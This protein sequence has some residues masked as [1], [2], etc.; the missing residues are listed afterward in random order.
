MPPSPVDRP[1][2]PAL[3]AGGRAARQGDT[4]WRA[5]LRRTPGGALALKAGVFVLGSLFILLGLAAAVLPGPLTIPPMLLGLYILA[6]E[7]TWA[8]R[9]LQRAKNSAEEA[10]RAAKKRPVFSGIT[11][12]GGL[13]LAGVA[14][15]AVGHYDL[16]AKGRE[17]VGL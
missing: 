5:R 15:W 13:V 12:V 1:I 7:F 2:D 8:D 9:L 17:A 3:E 11:T 10:W 6:S 4:G 14:I 16:V